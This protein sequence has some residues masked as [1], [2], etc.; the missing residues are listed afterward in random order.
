MSETTIRKESFC[1]CTEVPL[2]FQSLLAEAAKE[3]WEKNLKPK[4]MYEYVIVPRS[5][6]GDAMFEMR[7]HLARV[8]EIFS[9][10]YNCMC[11]PR[12]TVQKESLPE[13]DCHELCW[14]GIC[15]T[16]MVSK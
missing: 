10:R 16:T 14:I 15:I 8:A 12:E 9:K 7:A 1:S 3:L 13:E 11:L 4:L 6:P 5:L 2:V